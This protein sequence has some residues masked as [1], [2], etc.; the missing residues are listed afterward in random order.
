MNFTD[1]PLG[2]PQVFIPAWQ[3]PEGNPKFRMPYPEVESRY[4]A[5]M[6]RE[7][8][9]GC[10]DRPVKFHLARVRGYDGGDYD[11]GGAYW[12]NLYGHPLYQAYGFVMN[13]I[14]DP[15]VQRIFVRAE[16]RDKAKS[17]ILKTFPLAKFYR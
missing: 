5:P 13:Y 11:Q 16:T 8:W 15:T 9:V 17:E 14:G 3:R 6:G 1:L 7:D 2:D 12:G 10:K 4:G